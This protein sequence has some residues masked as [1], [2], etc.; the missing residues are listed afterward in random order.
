MCTYFDSTAGKHDD[1]SALH[2]LVHKIL[3][4]FYQVWDPDREEMMWRLRVDLPVEPR[5]DLFE[6]MTNLQMTEF[7]SKLER[8]LEALDFADD[9]IDPVDACDELRRVFGDDFPAPEKD[10]TGKKTASA[11]VVGSS[12]AA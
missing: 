4:R 1:L 2:D 3:D 8:L 9:A 12:H 6:K 11:A 7:K 10:K 5:N